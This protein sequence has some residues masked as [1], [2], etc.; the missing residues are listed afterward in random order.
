M[1]R[2]LSHILLATLAFGM[3]GIASADT[4]VS[5]SANATVT[6]PIRPLDKL[7]ELQAAAKDEI[8]TVRENLASST[9][10][11]RDEMKT[12][13]R[14]RALGRL[15]KMTD[16]LQA[17][18]DREN[19]I[20]ARI[21]SRITKVK[22]AG[23]NT[24]VSEKASL[25]AAWNLNLATTSLASLKSLTVTAT[26]NITASSS[27]EISKSDMTKLR[28]AASDVEKYIRLAREDMIK[29]ITSLR[30]ASSVHATTTAEVNSGN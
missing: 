1:K 6:A 9:K 11:I 21:N 23:G 13:M 3:A 15:T 20:L 18:I 28:K 12:N 7:K 8:K 30:G 19:N 29:A 17:T 4:N 24:T 10:E 22:N 25:D 27:P 2:T 5:V 14:E 26:A 16:R